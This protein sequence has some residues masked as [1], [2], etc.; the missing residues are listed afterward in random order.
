MDY[1]TTYNSVKDSKLERRNLKKVDQMVIDLDGTT[2]GQLKKEHENLKADYLKLKDE[3]LKI[4][5]E[6]LQLFN[7]LNNNQEILIRKLSKLENSVATLLSISN[8][9]N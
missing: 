8:G 4:Q 2:L 3:F 7:K 9:N 5:S 1:L 6:N